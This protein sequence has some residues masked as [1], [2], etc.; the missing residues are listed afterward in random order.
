[1][2]IFLTNFILILTYANLTLLPSLFFPLC[3]CVLSLFHPIASSFFEC[4][5]TQILFFSSL[6]HSLYSLLL[7]LL[8]FTVF[9]SSHMCTSS[10]SIYLLGIDG[11]KNPSQQRETLPIPQVPIDSRM[12]AMAGLKGLWTHYRLSL[13]SGVL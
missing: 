13:W 1:M 5:F 2:I 11:G 9:F 8:S 7:S 12:F 3:C 4:F 6:T 10:F